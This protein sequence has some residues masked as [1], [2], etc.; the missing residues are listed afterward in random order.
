M[1][2]RANLTQREAKAQRHTEGAHLRI[3][4]QETAAYRSRIGSTA[5]RLTGGDTTNSQSA[6][7]GMVEARP[8]PPGTV[9]RYAPVQ[10]KM[11]SV[12]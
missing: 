6:L 10:S 1:E 3:V 8:L 7:R 11:L 12:I 4:L 9:R 2:G 5:L